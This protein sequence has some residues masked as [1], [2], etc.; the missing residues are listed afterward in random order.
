MPFDTH[1]FQACALDRYANPPNV[2]VIPER[3]PCGQGL[4]LLCGCAAALHGCA[5]THAPLAEALALR[6]KFASQPLLELLRLARREPAEGREDDVDGK[7][8]TEHQYECRARY[9]LHE[10]KGRHETHHTCDDVHAAVLR[11]LMDFYH[12]FPKLIG[13]EKQEGYYR[14]SGKSESEPR[15]G[16]GSRNTGE[17]VY[18]APEVYP[19]PLPPDI[20]AYKP[21]VARE[22]HH[23]TT[24]A[25][26][27]VRRPVL[28]RADAY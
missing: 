26:P 12:R 27:A 16:E 9:S 21:P 15:D 13:D 10:K 11:S 7:Y 3:N 23:R 1:A 5:E 17:K 24:H 22:V 28:Q 14:R 4:E 18:D 25:F 20:G 8:E 2:L 6:H 19:L